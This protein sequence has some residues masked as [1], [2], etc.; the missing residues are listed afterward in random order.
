MAKSV[1][2]RSTHV[3]WKQGR[4]CQ[5]RRL[6]RF[7]HIRITKRCRGARCA[8]TLAWNE[9]KEVGRYTKVM[10]TG[11]GTLL[12]G[13]HRAYIIQNLRVGRRIKIN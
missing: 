10:G 3:S 7:R 12:P 9:Q 1:A 6:M 13:N 8:T 2:R 4:Y 11:T 5:S